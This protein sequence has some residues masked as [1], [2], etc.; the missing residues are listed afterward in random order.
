M[1]KRFWFHSLVQISPAARWMLS[2]VL[3]IIVSVLW[4]KYGYMPLRRASTFYC[5]QNTL[6]IDQKKAL[7]LKVIRSQELARRDAQLFTILKK[8]CKVA[9]R[10][11]ELH[12]KHIVRAL[13]KSGLILLSSEQIRKQE[14]SDWMLT[15]Y[16]YR[17]V[18][19]FDQH[20]LF[21]DA[22][23]TQKVIFCT[24]AVYVKG[25]GALLATCQFCCVEKA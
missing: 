10:K 7:E 6:L 22:L 5:S 23:S 14:F 11:L 19:I 9:S 18:G 24:K 15:T 25:E 21:L 20:T 13:K 17:F 8:K 3:L 16:E 12:I 1:D 4:Y 2:A